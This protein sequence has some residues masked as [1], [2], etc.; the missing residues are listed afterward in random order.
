[1]IQLLLVPILI[2]LNFN[3]EP[4]SESKNEFE[5]VITY[6]VDIELKNKRLNQ[7]EIENY[8][9]RNKEYFY[10]NGNYKW[11]TK[12]AFIEYEI[13][14]YEL[15]P[16]H[17]ITKLT[18]ND[19]LY[20]RDFTTSSDYVS[21]VDSLNIETICGIKCQGIRFTV[22]NNENHEMIRTLFFPIDSLTYPKDYYANQKAMA[23]GDIYSIGGAI[24]LKLVLDNENI[25]FKFTYTATKIKA[26]ALN[27]KEFE[28]N[29]KSPKVY[30]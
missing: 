4:D 19:S 1:M 27:D 6:R 13:Y 29:D 20:F 14:N 17:T 9:G 25:P 30:R 5:G 21:E 7:T 8:Y 3:S 18:N 26:K 2:L 23:N 28:F 11:A 12:K 16:N 10:K 15:D 24:P 22:N